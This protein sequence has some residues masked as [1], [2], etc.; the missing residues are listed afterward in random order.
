MVF[1]KLDLR[2][3]Y[4]LDHIREGDK[5]KMAFNTPARH[6]KYLVMPFGLTNAPA[7]FQVLVNDVLLNRFVFVNTDDILIFSKA[8]KLQLSRSSHLPC[9]QGEAGPREP[10]GLSPPSSALLHASSMVFRCMQ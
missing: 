10:I 6:Y 8:V 5:W 3:A 1:S 2:N 4:H 9:V 7:V